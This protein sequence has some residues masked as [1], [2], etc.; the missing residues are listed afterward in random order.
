[1]MFLA[2][3]PSSRK[4]AACPPKRPRW[5][6]V[7]LTLPNP[8]MRGRYRNYCGN[9]WRF[10]R[11]R[12]SECR[13]LAWLTR[14]RDITSHEVREPAAHCEPQS[15]PRSAPSGLL[16]H[17]PEWI[18][19]PIQVFRLNSDSRV[20]HEKLNFILEPFSLESHSSGIAE[21]HCIRQQVDQYLPH[22]RRVAFDQNGTRRRNQ[23]Q[24][25]ILRRHQRL[26]N[27]CRLIHSPFD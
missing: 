12:N 1:M 15:C 21:F 14:D 22:L 7:A 2:R 3:S 6:K 18:E 16:L 17:L 13:S 4:L 24:F 19:D 26:R 5:C 23:L 27:F 9:V 25:E 8:S 20:A 11:Q 10:H